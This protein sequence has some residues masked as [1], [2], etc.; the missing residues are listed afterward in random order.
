MRSEQW[1]R[2]QKRRALKVKKLN[3]VG[4]KWKLRAAGSRNEGAR[5]GRK[6]EGKGDR[7]GLPSLS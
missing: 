3:V 4:G 2:N 5:A 6:A 7:A 1:L